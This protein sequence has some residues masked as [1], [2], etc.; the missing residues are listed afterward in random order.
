MPGA[1]PGDGTASAAPPLATPPEVESLNP[2]SAPSLGFKP[3]INT[4][5]EEERLELLRRLDILDSKNEDRFSSITRLMCSVFDVPIAAVSLIDAERQWFKA[6]EGLGDVCQTGRDVSFCGHTILPPVPQIFIV[7][8]AL[9]DVRFAG[10]PLVKGPPYIRF[11]AGAPLVS[12]ANG[13][14]YGS[15]CVIDTRPHS[16][17][18]TE[19][20]NLLAQFA[21]L[22]VR[23]IEKDKVAL[24]QKMI[25]EQRAWS[26]SA[27]ESIR[28][29]DNLGLSNQFSIPATEPDLSNPGWELNRAP[30]D[31]MEGVMLMDLATEA[32][33]ILYTN[34][35]FSSVLGVPADEALSQGFWDLFDTNSNS[36]HNE[37]WRVALRTNQPFSLTVSLQSIYRQTPKVIAIDFK[38]VEAAQM[39]VVG[40]PAEAFQEGKGFSGPKRRL[41]FGTIRPDYLHSATKRRPSSPQ[42]K[43][44]SLSKIMPSAFTDVKLGP[45]IGRGAY[46]RVYRATWHG[47]T[48]AV[49]VIEASKYSEDRLDAAL[50]TGKTSTITK[51]NGGGARG[52]FEAVLSSSLSH[53]NVVHTYQYAVRPL[54]DESYEVWLISEYCNKGP[55]LTAIER[56]AFLT[57][58]AVQYGQPN[59]IAVLQTLQEIAAAM[60]YLHGHDIVHGDLTGGNVLLTSSEKDARGFS[61]KVVDFG[62]SRICGERG[63]LKTKTLGC[64]EYMPP[65]LI[66]GGILTKASDVYAFGVITWEL[67]LGRRAWEGLRPG[68]VL[69]LVANDEQLQFPP[70][71]PRRLRILGEGCLA[72][73]PS[74]RPTFTQILE[75]VNSILSDTMSILQQFVRASA[76]GA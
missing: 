59:L 38:P 66:R 70:Q 67:Y 36:E 54:T 39:G 69:K 18:S 56:G 11:Y 28:D 2:E 75:E 42:E 47:N 26:A 64:A 53:P 27:S 22:T 34:P 37:P 52:L 68:Q 15:L 61:A 8:D 57:Q 62:L 16:N 33:Q 29:S 71:T 35:S 44:L 32:W 46:G 4:I 20:Y 74:Q 58:P 40:L 60:H 24:L 7:E 76:A 30:D 48:V 25:Q 50:A 65:E 12:S 55:L 73:E 19:H 1:L 3:P 49:K 17:F 51:N 6:A 10:N 63:Y 41:Y 45:L 5:D 14:R 31:F 13:Y 9:E 23:E 43:M 21:E 72:P